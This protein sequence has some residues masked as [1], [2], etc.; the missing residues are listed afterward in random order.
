MAGASP[1]M[2][3]MS[4]ADAD[5]DRTRHAGAAEPA[6]ARRILGEIL[7]MIVLGKIEF[8][9]RRDLGGDL[10]EP[11]GCKRLLIHR[12]RLI[13]GFALRIAERVDRRAILRAD[14]V[15]LA[16]SLRRVVAFPERLQK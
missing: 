5:A 1:A 8:A 11:F 10:A 3:Q 13:G 6:I 16:H 7:L 15:A 14:V 12:P 9:R 4:G 2:T